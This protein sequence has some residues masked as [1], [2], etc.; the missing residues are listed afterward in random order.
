MQIAD[1][2][3]LE[4]QM[5]GLTTKFNKMQKSS[6]N[7]ENP[8]IGNVLLAAALTSPALQWQSDRGGRMDYPARFRGRVPLKV[9][10]AKNVTPDLMEFKKELKIKDDTICLKD[11]EYYVW[12]NSYGAV[13]AILPNGERLGLLPSEFDVTEWHS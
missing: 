2:G 12:V 13:S 6:I 3:N 11:N 5:F 9:V 8:A 4:P 1:G 10:V 7:N